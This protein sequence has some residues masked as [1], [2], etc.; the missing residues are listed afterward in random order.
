MSRA[1][2]HDFGT[3]RPVRAWRMNRVRCRTLAGCVAP[4][5]VN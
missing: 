5:G 3:P 2:S 4:T 1:G